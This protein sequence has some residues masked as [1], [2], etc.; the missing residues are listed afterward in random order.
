MTRVYS[1]VMAGC[2]TR[3][4]LLLDAINRAAKADKKGG[5]KLWSV[6]V[7][8]FSEMDRE[9]VASIKHRFGCKVHMFDSQTANIW[10][11]DIVG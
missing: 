2:V 11:S 4:D 7:G 3:S 8:T 6:Y 1:L 10:R 5:R 9:R